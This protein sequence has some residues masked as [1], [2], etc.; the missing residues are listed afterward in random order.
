[1]ELKFVSLVKS[2]Y[3]DLSKSEKKVADYLIENMDTASFLSIKDVAAASETSIAT[4][5]RLS[6]KLGFKNYQE[7]RL[8]LN[9]SQNTNDHFFSVDNIDKDDSLV[10]IAKTA[11]LTGINSLKSTQAVLNNDELEKTVELLERSSSCGLFGFGGSSVVTLNAYHRFIRTSIKCIYSQDFHMQLMNASNM[12]SDDC[13]LIVSHTGKNRDILQ[14]VELLKQNDVPI[15]AITSNASSPLA[16][17]SDI[18]LISISDETKYRPEAVSSLVA[19]IILVD[20]LF[21]IYA[22]KVDDDNLYFTRTR[23]TINKTRMIKNNQ[24]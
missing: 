24:N 4:I 9:S 15:I 20:S 16:Q 6:K 5:S 21:M 18:T 1:M 19:Q 8:L 22:L 10:N 13:A 12:T 23:E 14:I 2:Y 11:F 3:E 7:L 17:V